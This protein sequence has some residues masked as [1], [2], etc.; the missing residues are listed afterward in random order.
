MSEES[1]LSDLDLD[2]PGDDFDV[3]VKLYKSPCSFEEFVRA[4]FDWLPNHKS[5]ECKTGVFKLPKD[6]IDLFVN[7]KGWNFMNYHNME[8]LAL[9]YLIYYRDCEEW[10]NAEALE[11]EVVSVLGALPHFKSIQE[12]FTYAFINGDLKIDDFDQVIEVDDTGANDI[13]E[14]AD[15]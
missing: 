3:E 8:I 14:L 7:K 1:Y 15:D 6:I 13:T 11:K 10:T 12:L 2:L 4:P 9:I 5:V